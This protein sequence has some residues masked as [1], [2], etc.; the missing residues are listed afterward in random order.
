VAYAG[1][2][3][4]TFQGREGTTIVREYVFFFVL[5]GIGLFI[6][7]TCIAATYYVLGMHGRLSYNIALIFG[8][9]LGTLFRF[10]SYRRWVWASPSANVAPALIGS[11]LRE[12]VP[13]AYSGA[14][15]VRP[16]HR[17]N[18]HRAPQPGRHAARR[19]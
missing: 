11:D 7:L 18:S 6:Q 2:R 5:N 13:A 14:E 19:S 1:N 3:W 15:A 4:W 9:G 10:W 16:M 12:S 17:A 8:I